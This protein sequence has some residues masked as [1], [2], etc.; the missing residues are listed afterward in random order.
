MNL[1]HPTQE[2]QAQRRYSRISTTMDVYAVRSSKKA[3]FKFAHY[4]HLYN[5]H[6]MKEDVKRKFSP[7]PSRETRTW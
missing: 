1:L 5:T 4:Q 3:N 6:P 2:V 7:L